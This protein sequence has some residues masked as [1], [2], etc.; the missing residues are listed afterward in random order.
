VLTNVVAIATGNR[1]SIA[2][3][4]DNSVVAWGVV[5]ANTTSILATIASNKN[6]VAIV[7]G[8]DKIAV[9]ADGAP[10][11]GAPTK[12]RIPTQTP[13]TFPTATV[14]PSSNEVIA[15]QIGWFAMNDVVAPQQFTGLAGPYKCATSRNCPQTDVNGAVKWGV[16]FASTRSDELTSN[17]TVNL[18]G[19]SF[20]VSYWL[21]RD[22][23]QA[24]DAAV[25]IGKLATTRQYLTMGFDSENRVYCNFF[26][27]DLRSVTWYTDTNWHHYACT[28]DKTTLI[29]QLFRDGQLIAQDIAGGAFNPPA[30]PIILGQRYDSMPG[31]SGSLDE[32]IVY[33]RVLTNS[34]LQGYTAMPS[35]NRIADA[36]F[37]DMVIQGISPNRSQLLCVSGFACPITSLQ[38]H[39]EEALQFS[40]S[41]QM[42]Y[43]DSTVALNKGFT[44]AYWAKRGATANASK[45]IVTQGSGINRIRMG[46]DA[47]ENAFCRVNTTQVTAVATSNLDW[48]HYTCTYNATT[49]AITL[50]VDGN[51][52]ATVVGTDY[53]GAGPLLIGRMVDAPIGTVGF[54]GFVDDLMVY[55]KVLLQTTIGVIYNST[56]PPSPI[57]TVVFTPNVP[58]ATATTAFTVVPLSTGTPTMNPSKT[59]LAMSSTMAMPTSTYT[60]RTSTRTSTR[61]LTP[62]STIN[63]TETKAVTSTPV[64]TAAP[65]TRTP[66][67]ATRTFLAKMSPTRGAQTL[68]ATYRSQAA[69]FVAATATSAAG[70]T[71]TSVA[72]TRIAGTL[73][74]YPLPPKATVWGTAYPAP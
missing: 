57:A 31:L 44:I 29:R 37:E 17:T 53:T 2:L 51:S 4:E 3:R 22:G 50:Y 5:P 59:R 49:K 38:T 10:L 55:N 6:A 7:A 20:T 11:N 74:A 43:S 71:A 12:T 23:V 16:D 72:S 45:V 36:S 35:T 32:F 56:T 19:T 1:M 61:T 41:E 18:A 15:S 69:T 14:R 65:L 8:A 26:G 27:D 34:E 63:A 42:Q 48:H 70:F 67:I 47:S 73:T 13:M 46:F 58:K 33:N 25:S 52:P 64:N 21:R 30:S 24:E 40:G 60:T 39:D 68:T 62:T 66:F 9:I 28:F 54:N